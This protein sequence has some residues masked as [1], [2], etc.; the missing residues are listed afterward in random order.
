MEKIRVLLCSLYLVF[1]CQELK[2]TELLL[3]VGCTILYLDKESWSYIL[4]EK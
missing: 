1:L 2:H 4:Q 3:L